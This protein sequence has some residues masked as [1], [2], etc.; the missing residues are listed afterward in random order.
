VVGGAAPPRGCEVPRGWNTAPR[1][2]SSGMLRKP[3]RSAVDAGCRVL[4]AVIL[5]I[6]PCKLIKSRRRRR[7]RRPQTA[8][9]VSIFLR[10]CRPRVT[11]THPRQSRIQRVICGRGIIDVGIPILIIAC[12]TILLCCWG[13]E[14]QREKQSWLILCG[15]FAV[16]HNRARAFRQELSLSLRYS[17]SVRL[18]L[19]FKQSQADSGSDGRSHSLAP[20]GA[21]G[22]QR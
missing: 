20:P 2:P 7:F 13:R 6:S 8:P 18:N 11:Y 16:L 5:L 21:C 19:I 15:G 1:R 17:T 9:K 4:K 10:G 14:A 3:Q 12:F 22:L